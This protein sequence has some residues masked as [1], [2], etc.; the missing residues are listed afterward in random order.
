MEQSHLYIVATPIGNLED[1][2]FRA[3]RILK[4]VDIIFCEDT[5]TTRVLLNRYEINKPT[6]SFH[7]HSALT[8]TER[9]VEL[10][11]E[12]K[13][14]ALVTDAGTPGIS[15][16]GAILV[17]RVREAL[18]DSVLVIP[19]PGPAAFV[20]ALSG[21]G[22]PIDEFTF[23][24]FLPH[25]KGRKTLFDEIKASERTSVFYESPHRFMKALESLKGSN[26]KITV[27]KELTKIHEEF[28]SG[29]PEDVFLYF[30]KNADKVRGE[31]VIIVSKQ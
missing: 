29:S 12:G 18:M 6:E 16:P 3:I 2:T 30:E 21:A 11:R 22:V 13:K 27:A 5:R 9:I 31:F 7:A 19:I 26:K 1:I 20:T 17:S 14:I 24:G 8:K 15:D 23:Y 4:E 25:K 28:F 10:L